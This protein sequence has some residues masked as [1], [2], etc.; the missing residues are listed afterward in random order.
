MNANDLDNTGWFLV[1]RGVPDT[2]E[3]RKQLEVFVEALRIFESRNAAYGDV[4]MQYGALSNLLSVARKVDR[5][6]EAWWHDSPGEL[7]V[8]HKDALDDAIDLINYAVFFIRNARD[9][10]VTGCAPDRPEV[11]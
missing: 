3:V 1:E 8:M 7:P 11:P 10:N 4:W 9:G 2:P 6:M 5:T